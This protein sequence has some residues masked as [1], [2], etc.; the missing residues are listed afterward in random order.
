MPAIQNS[1]TC[2]WNGNT[3]YFAFYIIGLTVLFF[4][5]RKNAKAFRLL[6]AFS[7]L[8]MLGFCYNPLI[9]D[10]FVKMPNSDDQV[11]SRIWIIL[12]VWIVIAFAGIELISRIKSKTIKNS[13][14]ILIGAGIVLAGFSSGYYIDSSSV[15]KV[16]NDVVEI[17]DTILENKKTD[18]PQLL[19]CCPMQEYGGNFVQGGTVWY[20]LVQYTGE[21]GIT[22]V[23]L[24][25][26]TW[27]DWLQS[28]SSLNYLIEYFDFYHRYYDFSYVVMPQNAELRENMSI[29][30]Y[31]YLT[32][33][34]GSD[35]YLAEP[36]WWVHSLSF[37]MEN[38]KKIYVVSDNEGHFIVIGGGNNADISQLQKVMQYCGN[39]VDAWIMTDASADSLEGFNSIVAME[40]Y[41]IDSVYIPAIDIY[42]VPTGFMNEQ[43]IAA[44]EN[45]IELSKTSL[46]DLISL[47]EGD[48]VELFDM[49]FKVYNDMLDIQSGSIKDNS[50]MFQM[51]AG[52]KSMLFC[53]FTGYEQGQLILSKYG[54]DLNSD[55]VQ[56]ASGS[57]E[58]LGFDFYNTVSPD[59]AF[60]DSITDTAAQKTY[61]LLTS[62]GITCY[63]IENEDPN[64][65][66]IKCSN[67]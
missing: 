34:G 63:C 6:S 27:N 61:D 22:A 8:A 24:N 16:N 35:I 43:D 1:H 15:Y 44:Y 52:D 60:C 38:G 19:L 36:R 53:S 5:R 17:A 10:L 64:V 20:G 23:Q 31:K 7:I 3:L 32:N 62:N 2:F 51:Q 41:A 33:A 26:Q 50:M 56:I 9:Y 66:M 29:L 21:I 59:I 4:G 54:K 40:G 57:D 67:D 46:F 30:G 58:G 45:F 42:D 65:V 25:D 18:Y 47:T 49:N 13:S 48:C 11:Y 37:Y 39:H 12:P 14:Y 55:Y 28:D